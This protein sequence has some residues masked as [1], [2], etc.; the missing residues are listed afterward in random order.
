MVGK[1]VAIVFSICLLSVAECAQNK[2]L[3]VSLD[4]FRHDYLDMMVASKKNISAFQEIWKAGFRAKKA[5]NVFPTLTFPNHYSLVTGRYSESHGLVGNK[6]WDPTLDEVYKISNPDQN[7]NP[8]WY[9]NKQAEPIWVTNQRHGHRSAVFYWPSSEARIRNQLP[10]VSFGLYSDAPSFNYRVDRVIDWLTQPEFNLVLM[11]F[12]EPDHI[13]H[14][15]GP[16]DVT[17]LDIIEKINDGLAYLLQRLKET[18][19]KDTTNIFIVSDHGMAE[20]SKAKIVDVHNFLNKDTYNYGRM[21]GTSHLGV[22]PLSDADIPDL[23]AQMKAVPNWDVF[24]KHEIPENYHFQDNDRIPP[25][26]GDAHV[27][28]SMQIASNPPSAKGGAHGYNSS[29]PEM[30]PFMLG[31]GPDIKMVPNQQMIDVF[32]NIDVYNTICWLLG[33]KKPWANNGT[34]DNVKQI[35]KTPPTEPELIEFMK[36]VT[37]ELVDDTPT[38]HPFPTSRTDPFENKPDLN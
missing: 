22:W 18:N 8:V 12:N 19:M 29:A 27:G 34:L 26:F 28:Y 10:F 35:L 17:V 7:M 9:E 24:E 31:C 36:Y 1:L 30:H 13:S 4:G 32:N 14:G 38:N 6:F 33:L 21:S 20:L 3:M 2:V 23:K 15:D 25:L 11:Y 5:Q 16:N 37:G